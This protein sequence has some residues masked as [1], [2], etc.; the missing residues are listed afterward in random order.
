[1]SDRIIYLFARNEFK[2][3]HVQTQKHHISRNA[4]GSILNDVWVRDPQ[5][6]GDNMGP[7]VTWLGRRARNP[8]VRRKSPNARR[9]DHFNIRF[10]RSP[11][12]NDIDALREREIFAKNVSKR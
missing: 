11:Y 12:Q 1:M 10:C 6:H 9:N 5:H 8:H 4:C 2:K 7:K 3:Q